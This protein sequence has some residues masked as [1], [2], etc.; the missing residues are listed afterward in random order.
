MRGFAILLLA[1]VLASAAH[2]TD[3]TIAYRSNT[4]GGDCTT[5]ATYLNCPK[6]RVWASASNSW[7][8]EQYLGTTGA[9]V[10]E[11]RIAFSPLNQ[12]RIVVTENNNGELDLYVSWNGTAWT[13]T[14]NLTKIWTATPTVHYRGFDIAFE[15]T[16]GNALIILSPTSTST[17]CDLAYFVVLKN[18]T[19]A[20][21]SAY[22]CIDDSRHAT[23]IQYGWVVADSDPAGGSNE[24]IAAGEDRTDNDV[25]AWVW[26]G[27]A[28]GNR[29]E[30][31]AAATATGDFEA[32]GVKYSADGSDGMVIAA[33]STAGVVNYQFWTGA[34]WNGAAASSGDWSAAGAD[35]VT[36]IQMAADPATDDI[37][38]VGIT[39]T[40]R[41]TTDYWN[42][43][44][45][46]LNVGH[47]NATD[48]ATG[49]M[50]P[51]SFAWMPT[52][53]TGRLV[54]DTDTTLATLSNRTFAA[55]AW[56][57]TTTFST[58]AGTGAWIQMATNPTSAD[59]TKILGARM[60]STFNVGS[61][62]FSAA[63][64]NYGDAAITSNATLTTYESFRIAFIRATDSTAPTVANTSVN[65]TSVSVNETICI[66]ATAVDQNGVPV[67]AVLAQV[68][69]PNGTVANYTMSGTG[70]NAGVAGDNWYGVQV[71]VGATQ[72]TLT[73]N[74]TFANDSFG[75]MG[76]QSP[77]PN[78]PVTVTS[79]EAFVDTSISVSTLSFGSLDP[80]TSNNAAAENPLVLT[81]TANSNTAV[82]VYLNNTNMTAGL[83]NM[84]YYN[85]SVLTT[86][87]PATSTNLNG[88]TWINST[89]ANTGFVENLAVSASTNLYFWHD[90][91]LG[92]QAGSYTATVTI[93]SVANGDAP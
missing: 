35:D 43:A 9:A 75:N 40:G 52:G 39:N 49:T 63:Y 69:F 46:T 12:K 22:T 65:A 1:L 8:A 45:W 83:Y 73:I 30:V 92:Q 41:L 24:I 89:S 61:F 10:R 66:N 55:G 19:V 36:F 15:T 48:A 70:C 78:L 86:N 13:Q 84:P 25:N 56:G 85:L 76:Y 81:N 4:T 47:D 50:R 67:S 60:N 21:S 34:A 53:S 72:G 26:N 11:A 58:Y 33:T 87:N 62:N 5:A 74:T 93:R 71:S 28:W 59:S 42:G 31:T 3:A 7:G 32:L 20:N 17:T 37:M 14:R 16:S 27:A 90:V 18:D 77:Y 57:A 29:Q 64:A 82:D 88:S 80:G 6:Y 51:A 2:A 54:W 23:D 79:G 68:V 38:V 91:P 44:A